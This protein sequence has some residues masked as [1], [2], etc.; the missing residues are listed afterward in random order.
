LGQLQGSPVGRKI[1][2]VI[3][4]AD[5]LPH[6]CIFVTH[7]PSKEFDCAAVLYDSIHNTANGGGLACAV[8]PH[9]S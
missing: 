8:F 3:D 1:I 5:V 6:I 9:K 7:F 2:A 4:N